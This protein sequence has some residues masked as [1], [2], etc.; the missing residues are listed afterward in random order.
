MLPVMLPSV[1]MEVKGYILT[2]MAAAVIMKL[3]GFDGVEAWCL[4]PESGTRR[5]D[6]RY[7][8]RLCRMQKT[9]GYLPVKVLRVD[10]DRGLV[11]VRLVSQPPP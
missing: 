3:D 11:D 2:W 5:G 1:D 8:R 6:Q 10:V 4:L 7:M 9:L